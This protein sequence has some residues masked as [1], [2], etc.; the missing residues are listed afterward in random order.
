MYLSMSSRGCRGLSDH[1]YIDTWLRNGRCGRRCRL[2]GDDVGQSVCTERE[3]FGRKSCEEHLPQRH[4]GFA[5]GSNIWLL[6]GEDVGTWI[7]MKPR[8][9][10]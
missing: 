4:H 5:A 10:A 6:N 9:I 3:E 7:T 8:P 2:I 1:T